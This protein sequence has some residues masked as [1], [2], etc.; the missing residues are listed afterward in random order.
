MRSSCPSRC[1]ALAIFFACLIVPGTLAELRLTATQRA[2]WIAHF[3]DEQTE[4]VVR[5]PDTPFRSVTPQE[6]QMGQVIATGDDTLIAILDDDYSWYTFRI[7]DRGTGVPLR[8]N[9]TPERILPMRAAPVDTSAFNGRVY[10]LVT[11][12]VALELPDQPPSRNPS[13]AEASS[14][15]AAD[16]SSRP[17][18]TEPDSIAARDQLPAADAALHYWIVVYDGVTWQRYARTPVRIDDEEESG[19]TAPRLGVYRDR[20]A[21]YWYDR[22][23]GRIRYAAPGLQTPQD[24][25][26]SST[27]QAASSDDS[28]TGAV[29]V[30]EILDFWP[31]QV[32]NVSALVLVRSTETEGSREL[33]TL[34][35][36]AG[37]AA[38]AQAWT[39]VDAGF[40]LPATDAEATE[41]ARAAAIAR[42]TSAGAFNQHIVLLAKNGDDDAMVL[43]GRLSGPPIE[44]SF[45]LDDQIR[46]DQ[47]EPQLID[48]IRG[49]T[50]LALLMT[51]IAIF[52]FRREQ[53][54]RPIALPENV[55]HATLLG[56]LLAAAVDLVPL[57]LILAF[58]FQVGFFTALGQL[59]AWSGP[60]FSALFGPPQRPPMPPLNVLIWW[61]V[62]VAAYGV[63]GFMFELLRGRTPGKALIGAVVVREDGSRP[64]PLQ[65][66]GRNF[67]RVIELLPPFWI[68][69]VLIAITPN[70]QRLGDL[71]SATLVL[72]VP[73]GMG[74]EAERALNGDASEPNLGA[75]ESAKPEPNEAEAL[76][77][78]EPGAQ[79]SG[80]QDPDAQDPDAQNAGAQDTQDV[81]AEAEASD[82]Q[83]DVPQDKH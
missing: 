59:F 49:A 23:T 35:R 47:R 26:A 40:V 54:S 27:P 80:A 37:T 82:R 24:S 79:E 77:A 52:M 78:T 57:S 65:Y 70:R 72:T 8:L 21:A 22:L 51:M 69:L 81:E 10:A 13:A 73:P 42:V 74:E 18:A 2:L 6:R 56:R 46:R 50:M 48:F 34:I 67:L 68:L 17:A 36:V 1:N 19:A 63:Y 7:E 61:S 76:D 33:E 20:V 44:A 15:A 58:Q 39:S 62:S 38:S 60:D 71:F 32:D 45:W 5:T 14:E 30:G 41:S 53:L 12:D 11:G 29:P 31:V 25:T 43:F 28:E 64:T 55:Q 3:G 9:A 66:A 75:P 83:A 4:L 16:V